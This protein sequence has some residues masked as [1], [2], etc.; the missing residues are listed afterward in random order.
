MAQ[1]N[2]PKSVLEMSPRGD[3]NEEAGRALER[4]MGIPGPNEWK[5][6][7]DITP[8]EAKER[9]KKQREA[10]KEARQEHEDLLS[11]PVTMG[12]RALSGAGS[13]IGSGASYVAENPGEAVG[14]TF[15]VAQDFIAGSVEAI[16]NKI[17]MGY[18]ANKSAER[19]R[20][21]AN[22][23]IQQ[24]QQLREQGH[25]Q[26]AEKI[27][28]QALSMLQD[29]TDRLDP[30]ANTTNREIAG[31]AGE[32]ALDAASLIPPVGA[33]RWGAKLGGKFAD[34]VVEHAPK[35]MHG[36]LKNKK[37]GET[38]KLLTGYGELES[39]AKGANQG[40]SGALKQSLIRGSAPGASYGTVETLQQKDPGFEDFAYNTALNAAGGALIDAGISGSAALGARSGEALTSA[41]RNKRNRV[42]S[43]GGDEQTGLLT[44]QIDYNRGDFNQTLRA[45]QAVSDLAKLSDSKVDGESTVVTEQNRDAFEDAYA[46]IIKPL[47][48]R[49]QKGEKIPLSEVEESVG[50]AKNLIEQRGGAINRI[51]IN[52]TPAIDELKRKM[53]EAPSNI[54]STDIVDAQTERAMTSGPVE[55]IGEEITRNAERA[56][57]PDRLK[58]AAKTRRENETDE[59]QQTKQALETERTNLENALQAHPARD[60]ME[61][62]EDP[63]NLSAT[64]ANEYGFNSQGRMRKMVN[65][66]Q[67]L[68]KR[69][70]QVDEEY[71]K[72]QNRLEEQGEDAV[73]L[74]DL[75]GKT[76]SYEKDGEKISGTLEV[77]ENGRRLRVEEGKKTA[78]QNP[79]YNESENV[80]YLN[81]KML[82]RIRKNWDVEGMEART[83]NER[84]DDT[85]TFGF[86]DE[87]IYNQEAKANSFGVNSMEEMYASS[88]PQAP[89]NE[90]PLTSE[91]NYSVGGQKTLNDVVRNRDQ[92]QQEAAVEGFKVSSE[93]KKVL[94]ELDIPVR[95]GSLNKNKL[96]HYSKRSKNAR[97]QSLYNVGTAVHEAVHG[98]NDQTKLTES[99]LSA[100]DETTAK[101]LK[102][103]YTRFYGNPKENESSERKVEEGLATFFEEYFYD[104]TTMAKQY[105]NL[106]TKFVKEDGEFH[107][108][109]HKQLLDKMD[110][111][112]QDYAQLSPAQKVGSRIRRGKEVIKDKNTFTWPQRAKFEFQSRWEPFDRYSKDLGVSETIRDPKVHGFNLQRAM[113]YVTNFLQESGSVPVIQKDGNFQ[114][115]GKNTVRDY[116]DDIQ[117]RQEDFDVYL[118][119]RRH[120]ANHNYA[121]ELRN[122]GEVDEA[123]KY[124]Q[125]IER[126]SFSLQD[127][128]AVLEDMKNDTQ[129]H[130]AA[131]KYDNINRQLVHWA[132]NTGL[133]SSEKGEALRNS[134]G[135]AA[136]QRFI[137]DDLTDESFGPGSG[138]ASGDKPSFTRS[139]GG[140]QLDIISP[141]YSQARAVHETITK[142]LKN[143][144]WTTLADRADESQ[145]LGKL[146][147][148]IDY[149]QAGS[150]DIKVH[151]NGKIEYR[152]PNEEFAQVALMMEPKH[153]GVF[154]NFLIQPTRFFT[155]FT[156][157]F[158]PSFAITDI[159]RNQ[160]TAGINSKTNLKPI[161]DPAKALGEFMQRKD[162]TTFYK[163]IGG[164]QST[165]LGNIGTQTPEEL[166]NT[167]SSNN[168][169]NVLNKLRTEGRYEGTI[170]GV[171]TTINRGVD[172][173]AIPSNMSEMTI[174]YA[175]FKR[176]KDRGYTDSEAMF[177]ADEV[178]TPFGQKGASFQRAGFYSYLL[179]LPFLNASLQGAFKY[180][181]QTKQN[182]PRAATATALYTGAA[183]IT[184]NEVM[185]SAS[186]KQKQQLSNMPVELLSQNIMM[187]DSTGEGLITFPVPHE[188][189]YVTGMT[190]LFTI[191]NRE[192]NEATFDDYLQAFS[193][194]FP[195]PLN[196]AAAVGVASGDYEQGLST[197]TSLIPQVARPGLEATFNKKTFPSLAPIVPRGMQNRRPSE[198]YDQYTSEVA[199]TIGNMVGIAPKKID[200][201]TEG[202]LGTLAGDIADFTSDP[203]SIIPLRTKSKRHALSGR[204][205]DAFYERKQQT[206]YDYTDV[207]TYKDKF[208]EE[209]ADAIVKEYK[210][211]NM[212]ASY[213]AD[214]RERKKNEGLPEEVKQPT[215]EMLTKLANGKTEVTPKERVE[216]LNEMRDYVPS[217]QRKGKKYFYEV[218]E[219]TRK[220]LREQ[221][222]VQ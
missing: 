27:N 106:Y 153:I 138:G 74:E 5:W 15:D 67:K 209:E 130:K 219:E 218:E 149:H 164:K 58:R 30:Y 98:L 91:S 61:N 19:T 183:L 201:L 107:H 189:G 188:V 172:T 154:D 64:Q 7:N 112:A 124:E 4:F 203:S 131:E 85:N 169:N 161:L 157:S 152:R 87:D 79:N 33:A 180:A 35:L 8:W 182:L 118:A 129:I 177:L 50:E 82:D 11:S 17:G 69:Q 199:K 36:V 46:E 45:E 41:L 81:T 165:F 186:D 95:E 66:Y 119:A 37:V 140:S 158:N 156:T 171:K 204:A 212:M 51:K 43:V 92:A 197:L 150:K 1:D 144:I 94:E 123:E 2:E 53:V 80:M 133:I 57:N 175:E 108:D 63:Q 96:G 55:T 34:D 134:E 104:P 202:Y 62:T 38:T 73:S 141:V 181:K 190:Q 115:Q 135:Y 136:F 211:N 116:L 49:T 114:L 70:T 217:D 18:V 111:L 215:Y 194:S 29:S 137:D 44:S 146:F 121:T 21:T 22:Q 24:S 198:R 122:R 31:V 216:F 42:V 39:V 155:K 84:M 184:A 192:G 148:K 208:S 52:E 127:A 120:V 179:S 193:A 102:D 196:P 101:D 48:N 173:L 103:V 47:A 163:K 68:Q 109:K 176:A 90:Q 93:V 65:D 168:V 100:S 117:N 77:G 178:G 26:K 222:I 25:E 187:P 105:P 12:A 32:T 162:L 125:I 97:V 72:V 86:Q 185:K 78:K 142:G 221:E 20:Q 167:L 166:A 6:E 132:E 139:Y 200:H 126:E 213:I 151:R 76:V 160:G 89:A 191:A 16:E 40:V 59:L 147:E 9:A 110:R 28:Q 3:V 143:N 210:I 60:L 13:A 214:L 128:N 220:F 88:D 113:S 23:M 170:N 56:A 10:A 71:T 145:Q 207:K 83:Q 206:E 195:D 99:V 14:N 54:T 174:R 205:F 159:V 75:N